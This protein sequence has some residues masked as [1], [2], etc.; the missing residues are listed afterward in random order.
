MTPWNQV[1]HHGFVFKYLS[2][3]KFFCLGKRDESLGHESALSW[4]HIPRDW[5]WGAPEGTN[6]QKWYGHLEAPSCQCGE[7]ESWRG[8]VC[9]RQGWCTRGWHRC[10]VLLSGHA[11]RKLCEEFWD[12]MWLWARGPIPSLKGHR[13]S[14]C[15]VNM[16]VCTSQ[17][18][19]SHV[20][21]M[22]MIDDIFGII[23]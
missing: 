5:L 10:P 9:R 19:H 4:H 6:L 13:D 2:F 22:G 12:R 1:Y 15:S 18:H 20:L 16:G 7:L 14:I 11:E 21:T 23:W 17:F 3:Q 8:Q